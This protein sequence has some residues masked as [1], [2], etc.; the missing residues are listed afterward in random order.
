MNNELFQRYIDSIKTEAD[1]SPDKILSV[2]LFGSMV[3]KRNKYSHSTDVDLLVIISDSCS[4]EEFKKIKYEL[5]RI[6]SKFFSQ[7]REK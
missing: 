3:K 4:S 2:I 1:K 6:E 5:L 7:F